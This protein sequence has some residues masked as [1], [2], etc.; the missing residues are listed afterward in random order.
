MKLLVSMVESKHVDHPTPSYFNDW[1][2]QWMDVILQLLWYLAL[3]YLHIHS[4]SQF[5][6]TFVNY[7]YY[8][9]FNYYHFSNQY[10]FQMINYNEWASSIC[11]YVHPPSMEDASPVFE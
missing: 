8:N 5:S 9:T 2:S 11:G 10:L 3:S 4:F 6:P 7:M 1:T